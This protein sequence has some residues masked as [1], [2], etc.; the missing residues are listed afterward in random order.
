MIQVFNKEYDNNTII[1]KLLQNTKSSV[2][3]LHKKENINARSI[4]SILMLAARKN[5]H[6]FYAKLWV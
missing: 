3:F 6:I 5:S 1:V 4:L 2:N